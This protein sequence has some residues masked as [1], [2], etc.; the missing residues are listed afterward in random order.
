MFE[1]GDYVYANDWC[2]MRIAHVVGGS[3]STII[4]LIEEVKHA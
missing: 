4:V 3:M 2:Y 1:I